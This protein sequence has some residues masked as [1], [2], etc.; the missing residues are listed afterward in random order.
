[1]NTNLFYLLQTTEELREEYN[2]AIDNNV[3]DEYDIESI[4]NIR[5]NLDYYYQ[6]IDRHHP[7]QGC[8]EPNWQREERLA[9]YLDQWFGGVMPAEGTPERD[10]VNAFLFDIAEESYD[11]T[12]GADKDFEF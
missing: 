5:W 2:L 3:Y 8:A 4:N 10:C 12:N 11:W 6:L 9:A 1:M 7:V